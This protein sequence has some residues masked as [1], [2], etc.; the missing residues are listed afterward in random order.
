MTLVKK[1]KKTSLK[2]QHS[3]DFKSNKPGTAKVGVISKAQYYSRKNSGKKGF[4]PKLENSFFSALETSEKTNLP[5]RK[6]K[7]FQNVFCKKSHIM[8]K[9]PKRDPLSSLNVFY[10][11]TTSKKIKGVP[12]DRFQI[13]RKEVA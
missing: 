6:L 8:P 11:P 1:S 10:K 2:H 4:S 3:N 13:F 7:I 9:N 12:F 5:L